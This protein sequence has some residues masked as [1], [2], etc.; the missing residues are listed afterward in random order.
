MMQEQDKAPGCMAKRKKEVL[1]YCEQ[2]IEKLQCIV[3]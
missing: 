2:K 3:S 1:T